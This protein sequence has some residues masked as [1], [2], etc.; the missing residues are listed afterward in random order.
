MTDDATQNLVP[1]PRN[2]LRRLA[3]DRNVWLCTLRADGSPHLVPVWFVHLRERWWIGASTHSVKVRNAQ[4][5]PRVSLALED[6]DHPV[7]AQGLAIV[8]EDF[9]DDV[10]AAFEDRY[11]WDPRTPYGADR[12]RSLLEV[13][14]TRWL[15]VGAAPESTPSGRAPSAS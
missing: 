2:V 3:G 9:P 1:T 8:R 11:D 15:M 5:D 12:R 13:G 4:R 7:V 10:L 14:V 6:G